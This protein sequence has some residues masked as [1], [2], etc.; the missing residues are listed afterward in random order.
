MRSKSKSLMDKICSFIN[1]YYK[2]NHQS[3]SINVIAKAVDV[4]KTTAYRYLVEMNEK[5]ILTYDGQTL[6]LIHI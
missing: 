5:G 3:P 1:E 6:S 2:A 4:S